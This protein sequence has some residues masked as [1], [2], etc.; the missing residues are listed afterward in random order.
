MAGTN[1]SVDKEQF[2]CSVC[3]DVLWEPVTIPCGH[4]YC[5]ECIKGYWRK[6]DLKEEYSCPQCRRTFSPRPALSRNTMLAD[7]VEKLRRS[8]V[9]ESRSEAAVDECDVCAG[10]KRRAVTFCV[11]CQMS[12]CEIHLKAHNE[13]NRGRTHQLAEVTRQPQKRICSRHNKL[14]EVY[15]RTDR[16]CVC[17]SCLKD[18]HMGHDVVSVMEERM[19][20]QRRLE[21]AWKKS[22]QRCKD[23]EK[24][25][26]D[27]VKYIKRSSQA[28]EEDSEKIFVRLLRSVEKKH[29][30]VKEM[31][32]GEERKALGQTE[33]LLE[34]L[35][36]QITEHRREEAVL[37]KL[38]NTDD[39]VYFL[40]H[41]QSLC[42][43]P[44]TGGRPSIDVDPYFSL[45]ILRKALAELREKV[46]DVCDRET[47][48]ISEAAH[49]HLL[50]TKPKTR[51]DF[52]QYSC[53]L[54]L[55]PNTAN[56]FL[57]LSSENKVVTTEYEPQSYPDHPERFDSWAQVLCAEGLARR[58]YWEVEWGGNGGVSI[59]ISYKGIHRTGGNTDRKLGH[60]SKSWSLEFSDSVC[61]FQH[62]K[63]RIEIHTP[64]P[65]R[66]GVFL[67]HTAGHL[68]F[69]SVSME[70]D[71][72]TLLHREQTTITQPLY[73]G[74]W[75]GLGSTLKLC[76]T[77]SFAA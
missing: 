51:G 74:F 13:R 42:A 71:S 65:D 2:C 10:K 35:N 38:S 26:R 5:M 7:I 77:F 36:Q 34:R 61:S 75:V 76:Q 62:N 56:S 47:A 53:D 43:P 18:G 48:R 11:K 68:A 59:G 49:K 3:L 54:T 66:V 16:R 37:E 19:E 15:C 12:Y 58:S 32:R 29:S 41:C 33:K 6:C 1:I 45:L 73:P 64:V 4:S 50:Q 21:E 46:N 8:G 72:M 9:Q 31:I 22:K 57:R 23:R 70:D 14:K 40:Q 44:D 30:E 69:Y 63:S 67:D 25:L 28:V 24:E 39:H 55:D 27:I 17:S 20:K 52:L 60:N